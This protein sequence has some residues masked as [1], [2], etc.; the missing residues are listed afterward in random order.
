M[1]WIRFNLRK[2]LLVG[3]AAWLIGASS[4]AHAAADARPA[5]AGN[6][7]QTPLATD[8]PF[9]KQTAKGSRRDSTAGTRI[10]QPARQPAMGVPFVAAAV[11]S[12]APVVYRL[13]NVSLFVPIPVDVAAN[14]RPWTMLSPPPVDS[15]LE[16]RLTATQRADEPAEIDRELPQFEH[17]ESSRTRTSAQTSTAAP[18]A[19]Q[20][21]PPRPVDQGA[22]PFAPPRQ[23]FVAPSQPTAELTGQLLP[24]V[25]RGYGL[26]QRG[27]LFAAQAEFV[28]VLR[29]V[30]QAKDVAA[31]CGDHSQALAAG[32]R[33]L[34]EAEDFV[35]AGIQLEADLNV[36]IVASSHR[37][38]ALHD[39]P[40]DVLPHQAALLYH[41]YAQEQL[42]AAVSGEQAGS[43]A[44][45]GIGKIYALLA[46]RSDDDMQLTQ[47]ATAMY[48]AALAARRD[49][50]LAANELGVLL[51][52]NGRTVEAVRLFARTID[53]APSALAYHNLA[54]AQ[55]KLG[56]Q[57]QA[58][59]NERESQRLA[60]WE[61]ASGAVSRREGV[62]WVSAE[63]MARVA[64]P[65][66]LAPAV[67]SAAQPSQPTT[68]QT[69]TMQPAPEKSPWDRA[70]EFAKNLGRPSA[71][72]TRWQ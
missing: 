63:E 27:A 33:A 13:P 53:A 24:A 25:Q 59:A 4:A 23:E 42:A 5:G 29:R 17:H 70:V 35:P 65:A 45:H 54:V 6:V 28:Q 57:A 48:T 52:R 3:T 56:L 19:P 18:A 62:R 55:H 8:N 37:T 36:A 2:E 16:Q 34:D 30:A 14:A 38:P 26:A 7:Q 66:P 15:S 47:R 72:S 69:M 40:G 22:L 68:T 46:A 58:A 67:S 11:D 43:M 60:A 1:H 32:L 44:L 9:V 10:V 61:R 49:N 41:R 50:H 20:V 71:P 12:D 31:G 39:Q 51:C 21:T 64:Q